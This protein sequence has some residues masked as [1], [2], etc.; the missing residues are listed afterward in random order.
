MIKLTI[1]HGESIK[2]NG[3]TIDHTALIPQSPT[4]NVPVCKFVVGELVNINFNDLHLHNIPVLAVAY[5]DNMW[6]I[7]IRNDEG[8]GGQTLIVRGKR[9]MFSESVWPEYEVFKA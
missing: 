4:T 8:H 2:V 7:I 6:N 9:V 5:Y 3:V 1:P